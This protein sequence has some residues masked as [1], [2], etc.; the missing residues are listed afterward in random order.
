MGEKYDLE[1]EFVSKT[2]EEY[3]GEAY[4]ASRLPAAPAVMVEGEV[5]GQGPDLSEEGL[6]EIIRRRLGLGSSPRP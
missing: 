2:R 1:I 3:Q 6:E 4:R 5:A